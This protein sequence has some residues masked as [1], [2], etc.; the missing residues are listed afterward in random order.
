MQRYSLLSD[1]LSVLHLV[2]GGTDLYD[3]FHTLLR[4]AQLVDGTHIY[5]AI[6]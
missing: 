5:L 6:L 1:I 4:A 2:E 3:T